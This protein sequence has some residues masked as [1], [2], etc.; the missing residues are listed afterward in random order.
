VA[1]DIRSPL[2]VLQMIT[3]NLSHIPEEERMM[4]RDSVT[5]IHDIANDLLNRYTHKK[6]IAE[7]I[8]EEHQS[9]QFI[10]G[11]LD[12]II[13][14]KRMQYK[15]K[16][17]LELQ[18]S[19]QNDPFDFFSQVNPAHFK[20]MFSNLINNSVEAMEF[21]KEQ[22]ISPHLQHQKN[23][24][25]HIQCYSTNHFIQIEIS[26]NGK[27]MTEDQMS[28]MG[29]NHFTYG[30]KNG[31]GQGFSHALET[32]K[33]WKGSL[34]IS[35]KQNEGTIITL[36]LPKSD[37][38]NWFLS[39]LKIPIQA[40]FLI[41]DD[42]PFIHHIWDKKLKSFHQNYQTHVIH[43]YKQEDFFEWKK[44]TTLPSSVHLFY[45]FDYELSG[46][47]TTG[48]DLLID[49]V[50]DD[51]KVQKHT[52]QSY[53]LITSRHEELP[54]QNLCSKHHI[55]LVPKFYTEFLPLLPIEEKKVDC[56]LIDDDEL[57]RLVWKKTANSRGIHLDIFSSPE[58]FLDMHYSKD[59]KI[60]LDHDLGPQQENGIYWGKKFFNEGFT[61]LYLTTGH[62]PSQMSY[63]WF[64]QVVGK[65]AP[66]MN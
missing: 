56:I 17:S 42:D 29:I 65:M 43:F 25:I 40:Y 48:L 33:T 26:D 5:R 9:L 59:T 6:D 55:Y 57:L 45:L 3:R 4:I 19:F 60:F 50:Q 32:I 54:I 12:S 22:N 52:N 53:L 58:H 18:Y 34:A 36:L 30:K 13:T 1:H 21:P 10:P 16:R 31:H 47:M 38:P 49:Q 11:L 24:Q 14:E 51:H 41:L 37:P 62:D 28:Q 66:W 20:R 8:I 61:N 15:S 44:M 35:S 46:S 7:Q 39:Y 63:P 64:K 27:G 23:E 2:T